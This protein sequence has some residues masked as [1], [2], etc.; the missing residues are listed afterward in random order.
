MAHAAVQEKRLSTAAQIEIALFYR[1]PC[2]I[3]G[4]NEP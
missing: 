4:T 3:W 2:G 1:G